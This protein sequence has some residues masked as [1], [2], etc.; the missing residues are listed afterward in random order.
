M[1]PAS[2][3]PTRPRRDHRTGSHTRRRRRCGG[4]RSATNTHAHFSPAANPE[5]RGFRARPHTRRRA[6]PRPPLLPAPGRGPTCA[7][8]PATSGRGRGTRN[9]IRGRGRAIGRPRRPAPR[10]GSGTSLAGTRSPRACGVHAGAERSLRAAG[11]RGLGPRSGRKGPRFRGRASGAAP[12][13]VR[14]ARGPPPR[15]EV[16]PRG[17]PGRVAPP[18]PSG[19]RD[20]SDPARGRLRTLEEAPEEKQRCKGARR[21]VRRAR[22]AAAS[23]PRL[24]VFCVSRAPSLPVAAWMTEVGFG[25]G[26]PVGHGQDSPVTV[27]T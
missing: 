9:H 3:R 27:A 22:P 8:P 17:P 23:P 21:G 13:A 25:G 26:W 19:P 14:A 2:D 12:S 15:C 6:H 18:A 16:S 10:G 24:V 7:P 4:T 20:A 11:G 1:L 5:G